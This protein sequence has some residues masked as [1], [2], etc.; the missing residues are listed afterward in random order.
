MIQGSGLKWEATR[1]RY[2]SSGERKRTKDECR[3]KP[4]GFVNPPP[5]ISHEEGSSSVEGTITND[6]PKMNNS[7]F[8][9]SDMNMISPSGCPFSGLAMPLPGSSLFPGVPKAKSLG[10]SNDGAIFH[11]GVRCDVCGVLPITGPR[12]KSKV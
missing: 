2:P 12:F 3:R 7:P 10:F 4:I 11:R 1:C 5:V 6:A 9:H 8:A